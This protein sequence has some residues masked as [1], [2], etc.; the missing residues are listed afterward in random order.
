MLFTPPTSPQP[1]LENYSKCRELWIFF[2]GDIRDFRFESVEPSTIHH[3]T[4]A[5]CPTNRPV[6]L[7]VTRISSSNTHPYWKPLALFTKL[8]TPTPIPS[9][10]SKILP[11][12]VYSILSVHICTS[13]VYFSCTFYPQKEKFRQKV[14]IKYVIFPY[15]LLLC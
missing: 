12:T 3:L 14:P 11:P 2:R 15:I 5:F 6:P 9:L 7:K 13:T 4:T 10:P 8:L 1:G